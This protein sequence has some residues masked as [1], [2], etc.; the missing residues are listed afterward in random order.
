MIIQTAP[1]HDPHGERFIITQS[2]HAATSGIFAE[3][4]GGPGFGELFPREPMRFVAAHHDDGWAAID[5]DPQ[6]DPASRLPY[7]L[8][9]TPTWQLV[10]TGGAS[11]AVNEAFHP[12]SGLISSMHTYGLYHGRYGL[13]DFVY[14][15]RI[16]PDYREHVQ[17]M[18]AGELERQ[19]RLKA[20]LADDAALA[21]AL[22]DAAVF[23]NYKRLQLFDTLA[24]YFQTVHPAAHEPGRIVHVPGG[25]DA[26]GGANTPVESNAA[27]DA[28]AAG[29]SDAARDAEAAQAS[30]DVTLHITPLGGGEYLLDPFPFVGEALTF[31]TQGRL[32]APLGERDAAALA[33]GELAARLFAL[34]PTVQTLTVVARRGQAQA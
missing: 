29:E 20:A 12:Y 30:G 4:F 18:L 22:T 33:P 26:P 23:A 1:P 2:D 3:A 21:P 5:A 11:P 9:Q 10:Q 28:D 16:A 19:A 7:H 24:L 34:P 17:A 13:S 14:I 15:D 27:H 32:M 25:A 8:T 6:L 31:S